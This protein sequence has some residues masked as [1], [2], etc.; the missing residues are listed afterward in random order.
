MPAHRD[1]DA[2]VE[3]RARLARYELLLAVLSGVAGLALACVAAHVIDATAAV[4]ARAAFALVDVVLAFHALVTFAAD[5]LE[6][7][8]R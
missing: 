4:H 1:A 5:A 6:T 8:V 3:T 2:V 7:G